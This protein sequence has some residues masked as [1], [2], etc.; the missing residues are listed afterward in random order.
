MQRDWWI[1]KAS[2]VQQAAGVVSLGTVMYVIE[3]PANGFTSIPV[4]IY[5]AITTM[6]AFGFGDSAPKTGLGRFIA[7]LMMLMG[8]GV[9]AVPTGIVTAEI[10]TRQLQTTTLSVRYLRTLDQPER[11]TDAAARCR[12]SSRNEILDHRELRAGRDLY[13]ASLQ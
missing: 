1:P 13:G 12:R 7:S 8:W 11:Y 5:W 2:A 9:L 4:A 3:G 10:A 6:S